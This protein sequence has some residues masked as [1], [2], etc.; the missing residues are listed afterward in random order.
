MRRGAAVSGE[1]ERSRFS[2]GRDVS[3]VRLR[4]ERVLE[5]RYDQMEG[6]RFRHTAQFERWRPDRDARSCTFEQLVYPVAYDLASV[7]S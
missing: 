6:M 5:V 4:P 1:T 7:L 3:F 2:S